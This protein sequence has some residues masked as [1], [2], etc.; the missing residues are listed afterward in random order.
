MPRDCPGAGWYSKILANYLGSE[1]A[2]Y[3]INYPE[4]IWPLFPNRTQEWRDARRDATGKF[5]SMIEG[6]TDNGITTAGFTFNTVPP[7]VSGTV[8]RVLLIRALHNLN[9]FNDTAGTLTQALAGVR[10]MLK[11]DGLVGI[12]QHRLPESAPEEGADGSRGY[13]KQSTVVAAMAQAGFELVAS[14]EINANPKDQPGPADTVWRL[15]PSLSGSKDDP[16]KR[17]AMEA[18]GE[19]D[20]MTLLFRKAK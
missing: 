14:S 2:L 13:L 9:R 8:D 6:F 1:G 7:E 3:G 15:P 12:V 18:I 10:G 16:E 19:S 20:R 5:S 11:E 4:R 17:A